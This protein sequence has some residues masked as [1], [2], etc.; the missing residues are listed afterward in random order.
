ML[1]AG[2]A[3]FFTPALTFLPQATLAAIIL[4]SVVRLIEVKKATSIWKYDRAD[5]LAWLVTFA[6]VL[7][8]GIEKGI[9]AGLAVSVLMFLWRTSR[10]HIAVVGR[11]P[12]TEHYRNVLR[13][14]VETRP[15]IL[16]IRVDESLYF[17]NTKHFEE[18]LLNHVAENRAVKAVVLICSAVNYIDSSALETLSSLVSELKEAGITIALAEVKGPVMDRLQGT[19]FLNLI[20]KDRIF[21]STHLAMEALKQ[22]WAEKDFEN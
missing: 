2:F 12:N 4:F 15:D 6:L 16:A 18:A 3:L 13:H 11:V 14:S 8:I 19:E 20:G 5:G 22:S 10:P 7:S 21:L 9:L 17:P 1:I